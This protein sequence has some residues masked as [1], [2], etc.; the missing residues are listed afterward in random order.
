MNSCTDF[1]DEGKRRGVGIEAIATSGQGDANPVAYFIGKL[2]WEK[3]LDRLLRLQYFYKEVTGD[4][5]PIDIV[6]DGPNRNEIQVTYNGQDVQ[7]IRKVLASNDDTARGG[8]SWETVTE[9][10]GSVLEI[11][12]SLALDT[13]K[14]P[15]QF[16]G[17]QDHAQF[18]KDY[19]VIVNPSITE[20]LCTTTAEALA[21][22]KFAVI[23]KHPSNDFFLQFPN[24][25]KFTLCIG[26][27]CC[28][29]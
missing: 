10:L 20:V 18:C 9:Q 22:G 27:L 15:G 7:S 23:P 19:K 6:G 3:G 24:C 13:G 28:T 21:M 29:S 16:Y 14:I 5:F 11:P 12:S 1:L 2:L 8:F 25:R 4:F 26:T 17:R